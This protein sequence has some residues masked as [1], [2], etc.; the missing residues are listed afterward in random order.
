MVRYFEIRGD[1][2]SGKT[3]TAVALVHGFRAQGVAAFYVAPTQERA[4]LVAARA[5]PSEWVVAGVL[6]ICRQPAPV[7]VLDDVPEFP[8]SPEG[9]PVD[10]AK[11]RA[12]TFKNGAVYAFY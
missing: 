5:L 12:E 3:T 7:Y 11:R 8:S 4:C 1:R 10:V 2:Q 9:L 6:G